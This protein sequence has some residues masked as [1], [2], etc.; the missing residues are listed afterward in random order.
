LQVPLYGVW[1]LLRLAWDWMGMIGGGGGDAGF[2]N[3]SRAQRRAREKE[4]SRRR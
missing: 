1:R 4:E 2:G 3:E